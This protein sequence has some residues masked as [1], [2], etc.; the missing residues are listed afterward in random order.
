MSLKFVGFGKRGEH[1]LLVTLLL[2]QALE[3]GFYTFFLE[4]HDMEFFSSLL[5]LD[6]ILLAKLKKNKTKSCHF[7]PRTKRKL[8]CL[9]CS[10]KPNQEVKS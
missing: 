10:M 8:T 5:L 6:K 4:H 3:S 9:G 1:Y 2:R 7:T